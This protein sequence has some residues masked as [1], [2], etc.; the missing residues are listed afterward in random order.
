MAEHKN[1]ANKPKDT[2]VEARQ[3]LGW[4]RAY[5]F[6]ILRRLSQIGV[7]TMFLS[8]PFWNLWILK[9]NYSA[10]LLLDTKDKARHAG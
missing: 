3:K 2:G 4:W 7:I 1:I 8:G 6:L 5:R 9:G 10:S